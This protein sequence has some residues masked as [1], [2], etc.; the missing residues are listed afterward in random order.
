MH[1]PKAVSLTCTAC[2]VRQAPQRTCGAQEREQSYLE[3]A[4]EEAF[5]DGGETQREGCTVML[6]ADESLQGFRWRHTWAK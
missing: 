5:A 6:L 3:A 1:Q 4:A 2:A